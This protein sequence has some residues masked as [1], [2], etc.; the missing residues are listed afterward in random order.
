[1]KTLKSILTAGLIS[2]IFNT[3]PALAG[4]FLDA[5]AI[6]ALISGNTVH[7]EHLKRGFEFKV[8][9]DAD[10][11]TAIRQQHGD[12]TETTYKF[13][14]DKHCI[15]WKGKDRCAKIRDN[16]DGSYDRVNKK[17]KVNVKWLKI[18][19]GKDL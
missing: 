12:D 8:Y 5:A 7:S 6:K 2:L 1:M 19:E 13:K 15:H 16:G 11:E 9:F 14:G 17:G 4:D 10:G 3:T 18:A